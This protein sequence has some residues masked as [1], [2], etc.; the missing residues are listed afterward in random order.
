MRALLVLL[1]SNS[2]TLTC[3]SVSHKHSN[4]LLPTPSSP[5][6]PLPVLFSLWALSMVFTHI[7]MEEFK[8]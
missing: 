2:F 8:I 4:S 7:C 5:P 1:L 3:C 6:S